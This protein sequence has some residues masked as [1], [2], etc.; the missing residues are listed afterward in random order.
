MTVEEFEN[1]LGRLGEELQDSDAILLDIVGPLLEN[2][3]RRA[4]YATGKLQSSIGA[5][6]NNGT[7]KFN[8]LYYGAYQNYGVSGT[9]D[10]LGTTVEYGV[11]Q[12]PSNG[13][14][15]E[16][17]NRRFGIPRTQ[18]FDVESMTN[19]IVTEYENRIA[20]NG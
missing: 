20:N 18:F 5:I 4:P 6:V 12:R 1:E 2:M 17:Q 10:N 8:M 14:N 9:E 11:D 19:Y 13:T 15:Y 3:K 16:F 7:I